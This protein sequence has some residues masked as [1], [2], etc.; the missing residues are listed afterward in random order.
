MCDSKKK[1]HVNKKLC[2]HKKKIFVKFSQKT[3]FPCPMLE[4]FLAELLSKHKWGK[5]NNNKK[6]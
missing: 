2:Y 3:F 6:K 4:S 5:I 1:L